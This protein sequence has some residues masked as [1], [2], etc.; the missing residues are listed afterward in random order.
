MPHFP[1]AS[2]Q[3]ASTMELPTRER[4]QE[5][6]VDRRPY[7]PTTNNAERASRLRIQTR[8]RRYLALNPS[9]FDGS[10]LEHAGP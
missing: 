1:E 2:S 3:A 5:E 9:Y 7:P 6:L 8:R 10:N 4:E